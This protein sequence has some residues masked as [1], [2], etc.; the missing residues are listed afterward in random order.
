MATTE[1]THLREYFLQ[2]ACWLV[3][4]G[5]VPLYGFL[6][7][8]LCAIPCT[9]FFTIACLLMTLVK[10]PQN[11]YYSYKALIFTKKLGPHLKVVIALLL[12][13]PFLLVIPVSIICSFFFAL[14][15]SL[16]APVYYTFLT[17]KNFWYGGI[18]EV[19]T[20]CFYEYPKSFW[21]YWSDDYYTM[22]Q[23]Y[24]DAKLA[25]GEEPFD[26][27]IYWVPIGLFY[28][29][30][31]ILVDMPAATIIG[32]IKWVPGTVRLY[33]LMW[34]AYFD[35]GC[36]IM[37]V[38][39]FFFIL[40]NV[41]LPVVTL[42]AYFLFILAGAFF[43]ITAVGAAYKRGLKAGFERIAHS[44]YEMDE[45]TNKMIFKSDSCLPCMKCGPD[46]C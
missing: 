14:A 3:C 23:E 30:A 13:I 29:L 17:E 20:E 24:E 35:T 4:C 39:I 42:C 34:K 27:P 33:Y 45:F 32:A 10:I 26:V 8:L 19:F 28:A 5:G 46:F 36:C 15:Y 9:I 2:P 11:V 41:L 16:F 31:G 37:T 40:A 43:G 25:E 44:I 22:T 1:K 12:W 7:G 6:K 18:P 21:K 38:L